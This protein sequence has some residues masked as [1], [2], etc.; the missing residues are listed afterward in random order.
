M[1]EK[2]KQETK[3]DQFLFFLKSWTISIEL[4]NNKYE[5]G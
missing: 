5:M 2:N 3:D 1:E 4:L